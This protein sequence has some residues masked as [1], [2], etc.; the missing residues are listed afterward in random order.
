MKAMLRRI[1]KKSTM[2]MA[3]L[4]GVS[5][6]GGAALCGMEASATEVTAPDK[7][8]EQRKQTPKKKK[9]AKNYISVDKAKEA[10]LKHAGLA[11]TAV[12]FTKAKL[13]K[14][15][16]KV[17]YEVEFYSGQK[18]YEYEI[19]AHTGKVLESSVDSLDEED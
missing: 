4:L 1:H 2:A 10:A 13:D 14:D 12:T 16:G 5:V 18:E 7:S 17:K 3:A 8:V 15:D 6:I 19:D 11:A 9:P